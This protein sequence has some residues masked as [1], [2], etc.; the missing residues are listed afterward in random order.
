LLF[1]LT[2]Y[3]FFAAVKSAKFNVELLGLD[4]FF[5]LSASIAVFSII[6]AYL[7]VPETFGRSLEDMEDHY[8]RICYPDKYKRDKKAIRKIAEI[9]N[10]AYVSE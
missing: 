10:L 9:T 7:F 4:G 8:R 1:N 5:W 2:I 6:F 3:P